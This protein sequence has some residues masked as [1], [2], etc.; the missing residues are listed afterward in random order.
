MAPQGGTNRT[1]GAAVTTATITAALTLTS[2]GSRKFQRLNPSGADR[3]VVLPAV[4]VSS[5]LWYVITNTGTTYNLTVNTSLCTI[6]PGGFAI[7]ACE[8]TAWTVSATGVSGAVAPL[9]RILVPVHFNANSVDQYAFIADRAYTIKSIKEIHSVAGDDGG[10]V[11]LDVRKILAATVAAPGAAA[12]AGVV[13]CLSAALNLK[14]T[15]DTR[16]TGSLSAVAG[17]LTLAVNDKL[18]LNFIGTLT[19][20]AGGLAVIE[21]EAL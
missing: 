20:L 13:E 7:V 14:S 12:A 3:N 5:G 8:G 15:A 1:A 19:T 10:T 17:A 6:R 21:L 2:G 16:V 11:T 4:G 9:D 18:A